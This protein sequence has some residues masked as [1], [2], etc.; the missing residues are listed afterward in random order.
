MEWLTALLIWLS[1]DPVTIDASAA[2][3]AAGVECAYA[4]MARAVKGEEQ[5]KPATGG[6]PVV[7]CPTGNCPL[8]R[9]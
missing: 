4:S 9:R 6:K 2:R 7:D 1:A 8:P 3:A 5:A